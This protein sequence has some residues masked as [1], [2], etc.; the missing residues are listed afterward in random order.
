MEEPYWSM[1]LK[2]MCILGVPFE[3]MKMLVHINLT[4]L[5]GNGSES[6]PFAEVEVGIDKGDEV[7]KLSGAVMRQILQEEEESISAL[8]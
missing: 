4:H 6:S 5:S 8:V 3:L 7:L 1:Q 2:G